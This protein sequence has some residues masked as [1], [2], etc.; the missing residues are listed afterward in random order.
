MIK[1]VEKSFYCHNPSPKTLCAVNWMLRSGANMCNGSWPLASVRGA[2]PEVRRKLSCYLQSAL[3]FN[4]PQSRNFR[5]KELGRLHIREAVWKGWLVWVFIL[6]W[7]MWSFI[8]L[9]SCSNECSDGSSIYQMDG[10]GGGMP[11]RRSALTFWLKIL[12]MDN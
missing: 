5:L 2:W 12:K 9:Q 8:L 7:D 10:G 1:S 4:Y 3:L 6:A 11:R